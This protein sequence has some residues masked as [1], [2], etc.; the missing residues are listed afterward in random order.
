MDCVH[1]CAFCEKTKNFAEF[2]S[3]E[4]TLREFMVSGRCGACQDAV[5]SPHPEEEEPNFKLPRG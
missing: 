2:A 5:F 1:T 3:S 4:E